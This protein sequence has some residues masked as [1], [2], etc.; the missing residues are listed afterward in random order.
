ML[1]SEELCVQGEGTYCPFQN[2]G[3]KE[4]TEIHLLRSHL[5][6]LAR[7]FSEIKACRGDRSPLVTG[8]KCL[9][10]ASPDLPWPHLLTPG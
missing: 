9:V 10:I 3:L 1:A 2:G 7:S 5:G 6:T 8:Q 4:E